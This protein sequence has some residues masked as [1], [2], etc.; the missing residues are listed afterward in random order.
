MLRRIQKGSLSMIDRRETGLL[1]R[2]LPNGVAEL[3]DRGFA[4]ATESRQVRVQRLLGLL[5][6]AGFHETR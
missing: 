2:W 3:P 1:E 4:H 6:K 5:V